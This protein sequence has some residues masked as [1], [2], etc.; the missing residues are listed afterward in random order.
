MCKVKD[1]P[2]QGTPHRGGSFTVTGLD[3]DTGTLKQ[4]G[5]VDHFKHLGESLFAQF[6][7]QTQI[8]GRESLPVPDKD[9]G[10]DPK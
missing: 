4:A 1:P 9:R 8:F 6:G 10:F 5:V 7:K 2:Q 3:S